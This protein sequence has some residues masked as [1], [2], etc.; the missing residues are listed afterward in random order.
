MIYYLESSQI[1]NIKQPMHF[2]SRLGI[3]VLDFS[4]AASRIVRTSDTFCSGMWPE[5]WISWFW[6]E[7]V[8]D[9]SS[10]SWWFAENCFQQCAVSCAQLTTKWRFRA[11]I[12]RKVH[13]DGCLRVDRT[14]TQHMHWSC[15]WLWKHWSIHTNDVR[16]R[17]VW[18]SCDV[19]CMA[20][21]FLRQHRCRPHVSDPLLFHDLC[22]MQR[23][24]Q[25]CKLH[26]RPNF[27]NTH[28]TNHETLRAPLCCC[29][30]KQSL[31]TST[32]ISCHSR[33]LLY[34]SMMAR[35]HA[36][37]V[38]KNNWTLKKWPKIY[39]YTKSRWFTFTPKKRYINK[40]RKKSRADSLRI[41]YYWVSG[42]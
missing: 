39:L 38:E 16:S 30:R 14:V 8:C 18:H 13:N 6:K 12:R 33:K 28:T 35:G 22:F 17:Y 1:L 37:P 25:T 27:S 4:R 32:W 7:V 20:H 21:T 15:R 41:W 29:S 40:Q 36:W 23:P 11:F 26:A 5:T 34:A 9:C 19:T 3:F 42:G 10:K 2:G 24:S 31:R